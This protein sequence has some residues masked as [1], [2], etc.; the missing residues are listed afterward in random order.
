M[1]AS[2]IE[3]PSSTRN[4]KRERDPEMHRTKKGNQWHFGMKAHIGVDSDTGL[5][6]SLET[7]PA[8]ESDV[9]TTHAVLHGGEEEVWGD[10][11]YQGVG[12]RAEN[13]D[14][15][16]DWRTAMKPGKRRL[17]DKSG[18][19]ETTE[20]HKASIRFEAAHYTVREL[21][22]HQSDFDARVFA[23]RIEVPVFLFQGENDLNT[24]TG[25]ATER[26]DAIDAPRKELHIVAGG[27]PW[28]V[29]R[30]RGGVPRV[31]GRTD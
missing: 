9:A 15:A 27:E 28:R 6:H 20:R 3:A 31:C 25:L 24:A 5:A 14:A 13:R 22:P 1:D 26:F 7:T 12:K 16:V 30:Q 8:N 11:G 29:L 23:A 10:A 4:A 19:E 2:I 18:P 17:L 21:A